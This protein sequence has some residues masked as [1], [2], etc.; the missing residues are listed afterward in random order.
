MLT[1]H[2][3][4][5]LL[6]PPDPVPITNHYHPLPRFAAPEGGLWWRPV[7]HALSRAPLLPSILPSLPPSIMSRL[8][9]GGEHMASDP[10][11]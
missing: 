6:T 3:L 5:L 1:L 8:L 10:F 4:R 2:T 7:P 9:N 11:Q